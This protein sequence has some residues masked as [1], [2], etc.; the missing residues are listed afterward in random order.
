VI[1]MRSL[2]RFAMAAA[3]RLLPPG[4]ARWGAA[5][6]AELVAIEA[7]GEPTL[8][9]ALGCWRTTMGTALYSAAP[10]YVL[11]LAGALTILL[12][13]EWHTDESGFMFALLILIAA[14]MGALA[15]RLAAV[16]GALLGLAIPAAH[17]LS[18]ESGML[19]PRYQ[20]ADPAF[21][22]WIVMT[23]LAIPSIIAALTG[24]AMRRRLSVHTN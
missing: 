5:M 11:P 21:G 14:L 2:A 17:L 8:G 20:I 12:W 1:A 7:M 10:R 24:A 22:D 13:C 19:V 3:V 15:P 23:A 16:S 9:W 18:L 4:D 6:S